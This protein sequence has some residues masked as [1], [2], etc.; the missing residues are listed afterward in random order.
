M[1]YALIR[2]NIQSKK[3]RLVAAGLSKEEAEAMWKELSWKHVDNALI[4]FRVLKDM[5]NGNS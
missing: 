4:N 1:K 5:T 3:G 2:E